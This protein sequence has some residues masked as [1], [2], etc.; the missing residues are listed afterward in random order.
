MGGGCSG[1]Q[2]VVAELIFLFLVIYRSDI[3]FHTSSYGI[4]SDL[5]DVFFHWV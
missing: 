2:S 1:S 5:V 3:L 4:V